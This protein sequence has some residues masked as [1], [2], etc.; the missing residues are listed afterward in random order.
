MFEVKVNFEE[1][2]D[3]TKFIS[4]IEKNVTNK[5]TGVITH[6]DTNRPN[7]YYIAFFRS[8]ISIIGIGIMM[9][10]FLKLKMPKRILLIL[11]FLYSF[12]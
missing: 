10:I 3:I 2:I 5:L 8:P 7:E 4:V 11:K 9:L 6:L 12:L 1:I